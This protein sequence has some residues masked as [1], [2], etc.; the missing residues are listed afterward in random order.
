MRF[1]ILLLVIAIF[2]QTSFVPINLVLILMIARSFI[3]EDM[4]NYYIAF[5][6]GLMLG[7]MSIYNI[8]FW[9]LVLLI[10]VKVLNLSKKLPLSKSP[11][12]IGLVVL[13]IITLV[14]YLESQI[15]HQTFEWIKVVI[16]SVI[17]I[18]L[19]YLMRLLDQ[20][21]VVKPEIKL[22]IKTR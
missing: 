15:Y 2:L 6:A 14:S 18:T 5:F 20:R 8:G 9:P 17:T 7:I 16:E 21:S 3:V 1:F 4:A 13:I 10:V 22:K 12:T 19:V 11:L